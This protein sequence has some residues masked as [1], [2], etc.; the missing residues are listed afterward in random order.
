MQLI[1]GIIPLVKGKIL[2]VTVNLPNVLNSCYASLYADD[3]VI[4]CYGTSSS[5]WVWRNGFMITN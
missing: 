2:V 1:V 4:Y 5:Y 3:T